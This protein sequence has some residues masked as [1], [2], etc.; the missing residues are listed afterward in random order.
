MHPGVPFHATFHRLLALTLP[1]LAFLSLP[2]ALN[3]PLTLE[4]SN[5]EE[6]GPTCSFGKR[7]ARFYHTLSLPLAV[8][9]VHH[10]HSTMLDGRAVKNK[11]IV[12]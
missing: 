2:V 10:P 12:F 9:R 11:K 8:E 6:M 5:S 1:A 7:G 3:N 4:V